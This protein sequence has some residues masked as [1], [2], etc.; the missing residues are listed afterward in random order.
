LL[1]L[2]QARNEPPDAIDNAPTFTKDSAQPHEVYGTLR[3]VQLRSMASWPAATMSSLTRRHVRR[4]CSKDGLSRARRR[5]AAE[6]AAERAASDA[7]T[8]R[9]GWPV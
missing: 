1:V 8:P 9:R 3:A 6:L 4:R 5:A 7:T 2:T